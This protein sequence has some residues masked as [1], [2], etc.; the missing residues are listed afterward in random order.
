M[1][2]AGI[3]AV[4]WVDSRLRRIPVVGPLKG[5]VEGVVLDTLFGRAEEFDY[6]STTAPSSPPPAV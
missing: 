3:K 6:V 2:F 4:F 5:R 1:I